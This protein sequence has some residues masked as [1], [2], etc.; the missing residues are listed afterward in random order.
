MATTHVQHMQKALDQMNLQLHH[1]IS[2]L[3][4]TTGLAILDA[5]LKGERDP[6]VLAQL[7]DRRIKASAETMAQ[8]LVGVLP[9]RPIQPS[10]HAEGKERHSSF[11]LDLQDYRVVE[12]DA[13]ERRAE[14]IQVD[15]GCPVQGVD[16][17][18]NR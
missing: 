10:V 14:I 13:L 6:Q 4:G 9:P 2:D 3:T 17:I 12:F 16:Y 18:P 15:D 1:V 11:A 5:I 7:R 8:S